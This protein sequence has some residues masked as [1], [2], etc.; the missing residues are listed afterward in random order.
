M[1]A[2]PSIS[3]NEPTQDYGI[4]GMTRRPMKMVDD[5]GL[6]AEKRNEMS[7]NRNSEQFLYSKSYIDQIK[8]NLQIFSLKW[9]KND[10]GETWKWKERIGKK[11]CLF[12]SS[13]GWDQNK[14]WSQSFPIIFFLF[15][16]FLVE[17]FG[18]GKTWISQ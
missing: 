7:P 13:Y 5:L 2:N 8:V 11:E 18:F 1:L 3:N 10:L 6:S 14:L 16:A 15:R 9:K 4:E 17:E 12:S